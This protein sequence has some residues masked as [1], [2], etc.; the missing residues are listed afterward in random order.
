MFCC[1]NPDAR[2]V[3]FQQFLHFLSYDCLMLMC[4]AMAKYFAAYDWSHVRDTSSCPESTC[5]ACSLL[6]RLSEVKCENI[7]MF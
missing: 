2:A 6:R 1:L 4:V 5:L 7:A 3:C